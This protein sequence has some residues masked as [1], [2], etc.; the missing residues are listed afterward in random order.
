MSDAFIKELIGAIAIVA[1]TI[2]TALYIGAEFFPQATQEFF[3]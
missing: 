3:K 2:V 1:F